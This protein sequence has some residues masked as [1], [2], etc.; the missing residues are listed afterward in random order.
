MFRHWTSLVRHMMESDADVTVPRRRDP[1]FR[2]SYPTEQY[3]SEMFANMYLDSLGAAIGLPS[4]DWTMGPVAFKASQAP[5]WLN[6]DGEIWDA[7]LVPLVNAHLNGAKVSSYEI[8][9]HHPE[10][11][12]QQEQGVAAWNEKRLYQLNVLSNTVGKR[13]KEAAAQEN[14]QSARHTAY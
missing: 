6:N 1:S 14:G 3:H 10:S 9:Y 12:K 8:D 5:H 7:Q 13:M 11:M 2:S 4:I